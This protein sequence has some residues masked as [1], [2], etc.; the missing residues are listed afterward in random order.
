MPLGSRFRYPLNN[1]RTYVL[2]DKGD[3]G[4]IAH[5]PE[6]WERW[7]AQGVFTA[8]PNRAAFVT[9]RVRFVPVQE[10]EQ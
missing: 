1:D 10:V 3:C 9:M 8:A 7:P 2:L 6:S 4:T 5:A